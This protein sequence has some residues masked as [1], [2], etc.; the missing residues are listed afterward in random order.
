M[1]RTNAQR[2]IKPLTTDEPHLPGTV[3][4]TDNPLVGVGPVSDDAVVAHGLRNPYRLTA[5]PGAGEVFAIDV[6]YARTE[7]I[8]RLDVDDEVAENFGWPC[9]EGPEVQ[10]TFDA[11]DNQLCDL[12]LGTSARTTLTDPWFS[13]ARDSQGGAISA[14]AIVPPGRYDESMVGDRIFSD[15]VEG[16]TWTI[17]LVDGAAT[18]RGDQGRPLPPRRRVGGRRRARPPARGLRA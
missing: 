14:I 13:Y 1:K 2:A 15:Y 3:L 6:G 16:R 9:K 5:G 7:E 17:G 4:R 18:D 11:L 8:N 10:R 12:A